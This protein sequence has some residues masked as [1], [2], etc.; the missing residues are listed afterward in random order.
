M[1]G[2]R[3]GSSNKKKRDGR[4]ADE[5]AGRA[6]A[7]RIERAQAGAHAGPL[8][9]LD[10]LAQQGAPGLLAVDCLDPALAAD[11]RVSPDTLVEDSLHQ[12]VVRPH[13]GF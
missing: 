12:I 9:G 7:G 1:K 3:G 6:G 8:Q 4:N 5:G 2:G 10:D 11:W 13:T